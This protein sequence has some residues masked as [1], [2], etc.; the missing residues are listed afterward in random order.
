MV[1]D[2]A[3]PPRGR[4]LRCVYR[5]WDRLLGQRW[6]F[7]SLR[8]KYWLAVIKHIVHHILRD[9]VSADSFST[10]LG[11]LGLPFAAPQAKVD[12]PIFRRFCLSN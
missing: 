10:G 4:L 11:C 6:A 3:V 5:R 7:G 1:R 12:S 2:E 9:S 8:N